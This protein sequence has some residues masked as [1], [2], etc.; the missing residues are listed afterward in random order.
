MSVEF[1]P[2]ARCGE[3]ICDAGDYVSCDWK[4]AGGGYCPRA[5]C[6]HDCASGDGYYPDF[7]DPHY[8][9]GCGYCR[10]ERATDP[11]LLDF[12]LGKAGWMRA[13]AE[14]AWKGNKS[15]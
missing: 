15:E 4:T 12:L 10:A 14:A 2:C 5:W 1:F 3:V 8:R 6:S 9:E 11:Q 7:D 13:E